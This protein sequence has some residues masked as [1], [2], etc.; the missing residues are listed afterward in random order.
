MSGSD[1]EKDSHVN[2][3]LMRLFGL[4]SSDEEND[5]VSVVTYNEGNEN[6]CINIESDHQFSSDEEKQNADD[7]E[8]NIDKNESDFFIPET[9]EREDNEVQDDDNNLLRYIPK[10]QQSDGE[11]DEIY[12]SHNNDSDESYDSHNYDSDASY[13][14]HKYSLSHT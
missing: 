4:E 13:S 6:E 8:N 12:C 7:N 2:H 11:S 14:S 5:E 9:E 3:I 10:T 1:R